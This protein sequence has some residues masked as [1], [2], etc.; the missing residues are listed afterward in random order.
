MSR[1]S[2][3]SDVVSLHRLGIRASAV[4]LYTSTLLTHTHAVD[5][6]SQTA[7]AQR[8]AGGTVSSAAAAAAAGRTDGRTDGQPPRRRPARRSSSTTNVNNVNKIWRQG[9]CSLMHFG[10][11]SILLGG[12]L[13]RMFRSPPLSL[14]LFLF[15]ICSFLLSLCLLSSFFIMH[16]TQ[17]TVL[18]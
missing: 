14:S 16:I 18:A 6:A 11:N 10:Y 1:P 17:Y 13:L 3:F 12:I 5:A 4:L 7:S 9:I 15:F 2:L 8:D